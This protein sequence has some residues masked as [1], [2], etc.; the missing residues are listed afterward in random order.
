MRKLCIQTKKDCT[1]KSIRKLRLSR[2]AQH[3]IEVKK[4]I[5]MATELPQIGQMRFTDWRGRYCPKGGDCLGIPNPRSKGSHLRLLG[6]F[7]GN[8]KELP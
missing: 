2:Q 3:F 5:D 7:K 4:S 6:P 8:V 1:Y